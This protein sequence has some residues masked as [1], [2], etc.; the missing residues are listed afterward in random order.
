MSTENQGTNNVLLV[1]LIISFVLHFALLQTE[2][3]YFKFQ[4]EIVLPS[5]A[6]EIQIPI[7]FIPGAQS[8]TARQFT[9]SELE[10]VKKLV[11]E[12]GET[13]PIAKAQLKQSGYYSLN[14]ARSALHRYLLAVREEI[15]KNKFVL[16][17]SKYPNLV[18]NVKIGFSISG[19]G[20]FSNIRILEPSGDKLLDRTAMAAINRASGKIKRPKTTG[21]KTIQTSAVIKYQYGL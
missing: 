3:G 11:D 14:R 18:G 15:E 20:L 10:A 17:S 4:E 2:P 21:Y 1:S 6:E 9:A 5:K 8:V 13:K 7:E 12:A 16:V 19:N